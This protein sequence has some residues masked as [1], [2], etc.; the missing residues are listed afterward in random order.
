[1]NGNKVPGLWAKKSYPSLKPLGS[2][3]TDLLARLAFFQKYACIYLSACMYLS[4]CTYL[5]TVV[6]SNYIPSPKR[7][8]VSFC[9][10]IQL[11]A[12]MYMSVFAMPL[13]HCVYTSA[14]AHLYEIVLTD[15]ASFV[16]VDRHSNASHVLVLWLLL[17]A[18]LHDGQYA[19]ET[20]LHCIMCCLPNTVQPS[21]KLHT[22]VP[23]SKLFF[24]EIAIDGVSLVNMYSIEFTFSSERFPHSG[25]L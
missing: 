16:Q 2:Y 20:G 11:R 5:S 23:T 17:R 1:M 18:C 6:F 7:C 12:C 4:A 21:P 8:L 10:T 22:S 19:G 25:Y 13:F 24:S 15:D 14:A 3:M 9:C